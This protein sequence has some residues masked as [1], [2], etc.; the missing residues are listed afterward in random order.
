MRPELLADTRL[1]LIGLMALAFCFSSLHS[2]VALGA[3]VGITGLILT[4]FGPPVSELASRLRFPGL[5]I[6][7]LVVFLP[8]MSG[9]TI[10][11]TFGPITLRAEGLAS[12][13]GIALRFLC[14]F[15]VMIA[16][17]GAVSV[18]RL[19]AALRALAV[20]AMLTDMALLALRHLEDLRGEFA[21]MRIAMR[22]R[23][24]Q[25]GYRHGQFQATGWALAS[26]LLRSHARSERVYHAMILRGHDA[27]G[28]APAATF[29]A[30][31]ADWIVFL[32]LILAGVG[33]VVLDRLA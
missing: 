28:A 32:V 6:A 24:A 22:L 31:P 1:R 10:L 16:L 17:V 2:M 3:M 23:G 5:A 33:L 18:Q 11:A 21:R 4:L 30:K 25:A 13:I 15:S 29:S 26:L 7:G 27:P 12:A 9:Q 19:I 14:I 20:P 8:L